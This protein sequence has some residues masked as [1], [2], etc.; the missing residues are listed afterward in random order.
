MVGRL[1]GQLNGT[2]FRI[3]NCKDT[4]VLVLDHT[5]SVTVDKCENCKI[6]IGPSRGRYVRNTYAIHKTVVDL[7]STQVQLHVLAGRW[8]NSGSER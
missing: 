8:K 5:D 2:Q 6:L 3:G 1:P 4:V 7:V